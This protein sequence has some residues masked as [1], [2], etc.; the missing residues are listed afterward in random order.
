VISA[1]DRI[2][3]LEQRIRPGGQALIQPGAEL[4]QRPVRLA[5]RDRV[6]DLR[7]IRCHRI[8]RRHDAGLQ[9]SPDFLQD[10]L[11]HGTRSWQ[12]KKHGRSSHDRLLW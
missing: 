4:P 11:R 10:G 5:A 7:R 1:Q 12:G 2:A 9:D 3:Q 6:R 8:L